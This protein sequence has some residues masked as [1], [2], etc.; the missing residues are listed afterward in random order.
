MLEGLCLSVWIQIL[1][2]ESVCDLP[3]NNRLLVVFG[4]IMKIEDRRG[5]HKGKIQKAT[6][7]KTSTPPR[8]P[9]ALSFSWERPCG[10]GNRKGITP[11]LALRWAF[12]LG[13]ACLSSAAKGF[14]LSRRIQCLFRQM[15]RNRYEMNPGTPMSCTFRAPFT[16]LFLSRYIFLSLASFAIFIPGV[17]SIPTDSMSFIIA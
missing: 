2:R 4:N 9:A 16:F 3:S 15:S 5:R 8:L 12:H 11:R 10:C 6:P 1:I 7:R 17:F 13:I 14:F